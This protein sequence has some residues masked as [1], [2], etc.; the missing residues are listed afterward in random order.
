MML[1]SPGRFTMK[2]PFFTDLHQVPCLMIIDST[3]LSILL[4]DQFGGAA[5]ISPEDFLGAKTP[6]EELAGALFSN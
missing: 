2:I 4:L 1:S 3:L 5:D 6:E